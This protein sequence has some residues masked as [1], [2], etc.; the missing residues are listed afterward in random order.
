[1]A[2][3]VQDELAKERKS[4]VVD[5]QRGQHQQHAHDVRDGNAQQVPDE[6]ALLRQKVLDHAQQR[7]IRKAAQLRIR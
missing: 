6:D 4:N 5:Q 2:F 3:S 7:G 1:M